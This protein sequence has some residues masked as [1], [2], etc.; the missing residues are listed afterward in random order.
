MIRPPPRSTRTDTLFP[1][2]T[3]FRSPF[4][5]VLSLGEGEQP[6]E[7]DASVARSG[8]SLRQ[9]T[10]RDELLKAGIRGTGGP[11][12][13]FAALETLPDTRHV[14]C[15]G[16][17]DSGQPVVVRCGPEPRPLEQKQP[18]LANPEHDA[19]TPRQ[20]LLAFVTL[21]PHP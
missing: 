8:E 5:S 6:Q 14:H 17:L 12:L 10:W 2:T 7:A 4:P 20:T 15:T 13:K 16:H 18:K 9:H 1:Y 3:L 21:T 19:P 11:M